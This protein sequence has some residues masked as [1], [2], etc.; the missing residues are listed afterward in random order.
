MTGPLTPDQVSLCDATAAFARAEI[1]PFAQDWDRAGTIPRG[2]LSRAA[3]LGL[4]GLCVPME[5]GGSGL[6]RMDATLVY[7]ELARACP[8]VAAYISIHNMCVGMLAQ[9]G[10]ATLRAKYL[11]RLIGFDAVAAYC[12][13]EPGSGSDAAALRTHATA[14]PKGWLLSGTKAFISGA[15]YADL[16]VVMCRTG[17]A[18]PAGITALAVPTGTTGLSFGA[19]EVKLGWRAQPTAE[20]RFDDCLVPADHLL[21]A[22][23]QGFAL[24]MA[25]LDGGRLNIAACSLG[26]AAQCLQIALTYMAERT[27]FGRRLDQFQALQ[28]RLADMQT[29]L[30][31]A[32]AMLHQAAR[33][34]D[35]GWPD[36]TIQVAMAKRLC[37]DT[38]FTI[39]NDALQLLGGYGYL[40][41]FGIEK[42]VRDLRAHQIV[43][44]TNEVMRLIISRAMLAGKS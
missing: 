18:G 8:S 35:E 3:D 32:R 29:H 7:E 33:A 13:T 37:T 39:A 20:V 26:G 22:E 4:G 17:A 31:S 38:G 41:D 27:A 15:N 16:Y 44:G 42:I 12:L 19:P 21:A 10:S 6:S 30:V 36:A 9:H 34:L 40:A 43:E 14:Q 25:G 5:Q 24:A 2:V 28:F 1:A 23:G 11:A